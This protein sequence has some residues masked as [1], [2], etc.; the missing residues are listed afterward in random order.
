MS[1]ISKSELRRRASRQA[2]AETLQDMVNRRL[3]AYE[4][5]RR[6]YAFWCGNNA[7]VQE[8]R[9]L[10]RMSGIYPDGPITVDGYFRKRVLLTATEILP[11]FLDNLGDAKSD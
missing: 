10:F 2:V 3:D 9:P 6:L 4:G 7:A 5:Y 8:L 11:L 1:Q